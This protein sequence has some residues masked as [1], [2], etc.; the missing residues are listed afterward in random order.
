MSALN[1]LLKESQ[2]WGKS[3]CKYDGGDKKVQMVV[4]E[5]F[6]HLA[7]S[8]QG[9]LDNIVNSKPEHRAVYGLLF[10]SMVAFSYTSL[11]QRVLI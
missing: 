3:V 7:F 4:S 11:L 1:C 10:F 9:L 8:L 5:A 2:F 6:N